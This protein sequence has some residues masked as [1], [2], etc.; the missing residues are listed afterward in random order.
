MEP[1]NIS[2]APMIIQIFQMSITC[3]YCIKHKIFIHCQGIGSDLDHVLVL[4][5]N[6]SR[7]LKVDEVEVQPPKMNME[8]PVAWYTAQWE[9]RLLTPPIITFKTRL[10]MI[11]APL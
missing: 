9:Y 3:I 10:F 8:W 1:H 11:A 7:S 5:L 2:Y 6:C 4:R